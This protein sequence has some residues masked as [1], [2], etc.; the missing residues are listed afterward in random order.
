MVQK[1]A[2]LRPAMRSMHACDHVRRHILHI[3]NM[4]DN[5]SRT[6]IKATCSCV[7]ALCCV[8]NQQPGRKLCARTCQRLRWMLVRASGAIATGFMPMQP[9]FVV[10]LFLVS[11]RPPA[12]KPELGASLKQLI[13][14]S[15]PKQASAPARFSAALSKLQCRGAKGRS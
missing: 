5:L 4:S 13:Q 11:V 6:G 10:R 2:I 12:P 8:L 9:Y 1:K 15:R 7:A 14:L 3:A